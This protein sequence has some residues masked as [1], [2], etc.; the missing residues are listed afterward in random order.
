MRGARCNID[1]YIQGLLLL[2]PSVMTLLPISKSISIWILCL[3]CFYIQVS[4][5]PWAGRNENRRRRIEGGESWS[6]RRAHIILLGLVWDGDL[7][8]QSDLSFFSFEIKVD[9]AKRV[10]NTGVGR[11]HFS[12][13]SNTG[14]T[15]SIPLHRINPISCIYL[16][17]KHFERQS[18]HYQYD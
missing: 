15:Y 9:I 17:Q 16:I 4:R 3:R 1:S 13:Y 6:T 18:V 8:I 11:C 14:F 5:V 7:E 10:Y 2:S 12:V